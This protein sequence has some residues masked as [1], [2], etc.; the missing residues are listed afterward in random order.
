MMTFIGRS[1][2]CFVKFE[3]Y[4]IILCMYGSILANS[5]WVWLAAAVLFI[6]IEVFTMGLTTVWFAVGAIAMIF[7]CK[8]PIPFSIQILI[9]LGISILLMLLTRPFFIEKL[10][11]GKEKTNVDSLIGKRSLVVKK[12]TGLKKGEI[13]IGGDIWSAKSE[14][15][16]E[17]PEKTKCEIVR[18]E[19]SSAV[20]KPVSE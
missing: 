11:V 8:L 17:I 4:D 2:F 6:L 1:F 14:D 12:I 10:K 13:E 5:S 15:G 9:F 7:L 3:I 16:S 18:I 19:G 20:V